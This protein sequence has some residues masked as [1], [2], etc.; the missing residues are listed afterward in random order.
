MIRS[1]TIL[2]VCAALGCAG[3][4]PAPAVTATPAVGAPSVAPGV[5]AEVQ[6][7]GFSAE[8]PSEP[9]A[10]T[11]LRDQSFVA[12]LT[13]GDALRH[14]AW[15]VSMQGRD[16]PKDAEWLSRM[17]RSLKLQKR[18]DVELS[19]MM[20][21]ELAGKQDGTSSLQRLFVRGDSLCTAS[22]MDKSGRDIDEA[23]A[24]RFFDSL[25]FEQ[26]WYVFASPGERFSV[27]VPAHAIELVDPGD[28]EDE[29][30]GEA[31]EEEDTNEGFTMHTFF[32]GGKDELAYWASSQVMFGPRS[33]DVTDDQ[34]L[35]IA[36]EAMAKQDN[37]LAFQAPI[38][39]NGVR[40][41]E[42]LSTKGKGVYTGR[43]LLTSDFLYMLM[44]GANSRE[45]LQRAEKTRFYESF[46]HY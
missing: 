29:K 33:P 45:A 34:I 31:D 3:R 21:V 24:A 40:G 39:V 36:M 7:F 13:T 23:V 26:P 1:W 28:H 42:F 22:L 38:V 6:G 35:D 41:R 10:S 4:A 14:V 43:L 37:K 5:R 17:E 8:F 16:R 11:S 9:T 27:A 2:L 19:G 25:R 32:V 30:E 46:V 20:G 15:C 12:E 44:I 18:A